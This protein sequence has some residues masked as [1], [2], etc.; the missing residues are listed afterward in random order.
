M[1]SEPKGSE[2]EGEGARLRPFTL[3]FTLTFNAR[4]IA[5]EQAPASSAGFQIH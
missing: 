3:T 5:C 2:R 1:E 4:G